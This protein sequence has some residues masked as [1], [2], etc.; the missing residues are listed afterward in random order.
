MQKDVYRIPT[1]LVLSG[2]SALDGVE[3][4][5]GVVEYIDAYWEYHEDDPTAVRLVLLDDCPEQNNVWV[6][7]RELLRQAFSMPF[8]SVGELDVK[9][10]MAR[11]RTLIS[12]E[13]DEGWASLL[14]NTHDARKFLKG[15]YEIISREEEDKIMEA[16]VDN[17]LNQM[18][19]LGYA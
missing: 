17:F 1:R 16:T 14:A 18:D 10:T 8:R 15:T 11:T 4:P 5:K 6:F 12:L 13:T 2:A 7:A 19:K 9:I 3:R